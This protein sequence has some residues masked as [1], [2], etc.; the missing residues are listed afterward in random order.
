MAVPNP[1]KRIL[2]SAVVFIW[3][4]WDPQLYNKLFTNPTL[5][6]GRIINVLPL[7]AVLLVPAAAA[8]VRRSRPLALG[9]AGAGEATPPVG[10]DGGVE[11]EGQQLCL[12][13]LLAVHLLLVRDYWAPGVFQYLP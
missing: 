3:I 12:R 7:R 4:T 5:C 11:A 13:E 10:Q 8:L 6:A 1:N 2:N 9:L